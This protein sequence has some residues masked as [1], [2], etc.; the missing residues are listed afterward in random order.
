MTWASNYL[1]RFVKEEDGVTIVE[2]VI[3]IA[4]VLILLVPTLKNLGETENERLKEIET[5]ISK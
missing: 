4:V 3:I 2:M 1:A 5:M